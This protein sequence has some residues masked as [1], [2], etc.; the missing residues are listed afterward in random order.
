MLRHNDYWT[1]TDRQR[2]AAALRQV[3]DSIREAEK[4]DCAWRWKYLCLGMILAGLFILFFTSC[5]HAQEIPED[6]AVKAIIGEAENQGYDGMLAVSCALRNRG[7]LR[8]VFG[9]NAPRVKKGLYTRG[10]YLKAK[11]AWNE[12]KLDEAN[13][14]LDKY[15]TPILID[16]CSFMK[17][18]NSWENLNAFGKPYWADTCKQTVIV[19]DHVFFKC[20]TPKRR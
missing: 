14:T 9:V 11:E 8:G 6:Q 15:G 18:A 17:G 1:N 13:M 19:K 3:R 5:A 10:T 4:P 20:P 7:T 12:S 16:K 2:T